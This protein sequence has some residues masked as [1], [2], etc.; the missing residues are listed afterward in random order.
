M[1]QQM[2]DQ[3]NAESS[4]KSRSLDPL[5]ERP[6][7]RLMGEIPKRFVTMI[8]KFL[9]MKGVAFI[10]ATYLVV[11]GGISEYTWLAVTLVLIF[12]EKALGV[13][14]DIRHGT[15]GGTQVPEVYRG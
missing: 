5:M 7:T 6:L 1:T 2:I 4:A 10:T 8:H 12:G 14:K 11:H 15:S 13:I 9:S 3:A